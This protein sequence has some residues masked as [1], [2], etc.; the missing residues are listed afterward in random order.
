MRRVRRISLRDFRS[1]EALDIRTDA[2]AIV[3]YGPNG[4]GKT[5]LLEALSLM[6]PGRGL[7]RATA[8]EVARQKGA[9][10][11]GIGIG[12]G[13]EDDEFSLSLRAEPPEPLRKVAQIDGA[14][15]SSSTVF[16]DHLRFAWLTPAQDRL[17]LDAPGDRRRFLDR[18]VLTGDA[19]HAPRSL[20]YEKAMRQRQA[21]LSDKWD[22][23]LLSLLESQMAEHGAA[24]VA[25]RQ[26]TLEELAS[27][28]ASLRTGAF[29][30]ALLALSGP[31]EEAIAAGQSLAEIEMWLK[32]DLARSRRRDTEAGR[33]LAGPHRA[34]LAVTH[35]EK[36]Q[37]AKFCS[38]GEQKALLVG[39]VLAH[40]ASEAQR[41]GAPLILLLD[42][43]SAHLDGARRA[44]LAEI[45]ASLRIQAF[46]TGTDREPF[47]PWSNSALMIEIGEGGRA[48][49]E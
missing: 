19:A 44:A 48:H 46:M 14:S 42:E 27:G 15:V 28:Y 17:F 32:G 3:L 45:L 38:T 8:A 16:A 35:R 24:I 41:S 13:D 10:G 12:L 22:Q 29:P 6:G 11:W 36:N 21:V 7:R 37:A 40:A 43:I 4:A 23:G 33:A 9:G 2:G 39:L 30:G 18:M 20:A 47:S 25:A 31:Y 5:N 34:D 26:R 1:Y 49:P